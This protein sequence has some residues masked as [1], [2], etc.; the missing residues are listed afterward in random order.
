MWMRINVAAFAFSEDLWMDTEDFP[1]HGVAMWE[2][3]I[4]RASG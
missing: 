1:V 4:I 2:V 3:G